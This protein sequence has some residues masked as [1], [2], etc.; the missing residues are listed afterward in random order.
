MILVGELWY[1]LSLETV[2]PSRLPVTFPRLCSALFALCAFELV[3]E[4]PHRANFLRV[5]SIF[6]ELVAVR[7]EVELTVAVL[8]NCADDESP[9]R[10]NDAAGFV[11]EHV[12]FPKLQGPDAL[13][14]RG[15]QSSFVI[16][17]WLWAGIAR[18]ASAVLAVLSMLRV[19]AAVVLLWFC[20]L[21]WLPPRGLPLVVRLRLWLLVFLCSL[22]RPFSLCLLMLLRS[23]LGSGSALAAASS[24]FFEVDVI[25]IV[26]F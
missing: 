18:G 8:R 5:A 22:L 1:R 11:D 12:R 16:F 19:G 4:L 20:M 10:W 2:S 9:V 13:L 7:R 6:E 3:A 23:L 14:L 15:L 17:G 24:S 21:S 25:R 26:L